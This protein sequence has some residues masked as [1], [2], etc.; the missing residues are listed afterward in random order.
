MEVRRRG[1][2]VFNK[3]R[4]I[5]G[6]ALGFTVTAC[7]SPFVS[8]NGHM[9]AFS[10]LKA[11]RC[12]SSQVRN[13]CYLFARAVLI[14]FPEKYQELQENGVRAEGRRRANCA[15]EEM[16]DGKCPP[17]CLCVKTTT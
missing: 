2:A 9:E 14:K 5:S 17:P 15:P 3:C 12:T 13:I 8:H 1:N 11:D 10:R 7:L 6:C 16:S 4:S